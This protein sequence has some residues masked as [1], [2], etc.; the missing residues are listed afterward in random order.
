[1]MFEPRGSATGSLAFAAAAA[2][3]SALSFSPGFTT[4]TFVIFFSILCALIA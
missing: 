2:S 1:M 4:R 3:A